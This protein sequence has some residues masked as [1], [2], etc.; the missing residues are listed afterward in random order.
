M[1][2]D[3]EAEIQD[4][5][6]DRQGAPKGWGPVPVHSHTQ[7]RFLWRAAQVCLA[8]MRRPYHYRHFQVQFL[9][10][11]RQVATASTGRQHQLPRACRHLVR[12]PTVENGEHIESTENGETIGCR[13]PSACEIKDE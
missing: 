5:P 13:F 2:Q 3:R 12:A 7:V 11:T 1:A 4:A 8:S 6:K 10:R 9:V